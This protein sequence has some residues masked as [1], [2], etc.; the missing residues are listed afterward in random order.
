MSSQS[1]LAGILPGDHERA[2]RA[3][4]ECT[5]PP[6]RSETGILFHRNLDIGQSRINSRET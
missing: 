5:R 3:R 2:V 6:V 4:S 1:H